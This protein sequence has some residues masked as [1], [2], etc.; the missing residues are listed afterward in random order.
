MS[1]WKEQREAEAKAE[2]AKMQEEQNEPQNLQEIEDSFKDAFN[3]DKLLQTFAEKRYKEAG[4]MDD[5][6]DTNYYFCVCFNNFN[7]LCEFCENFN[8]NPDDIYVDGKTFAKQMK[9]ALLEPDI[10]LP[11]TQG[12][13]KDYLARSLDK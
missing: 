13:N 9:R 8:L 3:T 1:K 10:E 11:K 5:I 12:L 2:A 7:Q 4:R 6:I